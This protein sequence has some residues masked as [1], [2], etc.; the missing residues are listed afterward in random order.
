MKRS[1]L[2]Y[3]LLI[4]LTSGFGQNLYFPPVN[5][6]QWDT[7]GLTE[8]GWCADQLPP[9]YDFLESSNTKA[10][11]VLKDGK[12]AIEKY[13][14]SFTQDSLWYWASAGKT[15]TAFMVGKAQ[16]EGFLEISDTS[17]TYLGQGW[18]SLPSAQEEKI[19]VR[20]Q[21]T[22]TTG[23][24]DGVTDVNCTL[25]S[26]LQYLA[27][28]GTRWSYHNAPYTLL[29]DVVAAATNSNFNLYLNTKLKVPT[30]MDGLFVPVPPYQSVYFS[31]PRSMAR[32][33]LLML[34][35]GNWNGTQVMTDINYLNEMVTPSQTINNSYGYLWWLN[36]Q[37]S[38]MLPGI[39]IA[40]PGNLMP[41]APTDVYAAMGKNG[42]ILN[43]SPS[44]N[45][46]VVRMGDSPDNSFVP[47]L[48]N[49]TI[50]Q[51]LNPVMCGT[52]SEPSYENNDLNFYP[53]PTNGNLTINGIDKTGTLKLYSMDGRLMWKKFLSNDN[54][55]L[56]IPERIPRGIYIINISSEATSI[57]KKV[58]LK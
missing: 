50:W 1:I 35:N 37:S 49:D 38:F 25:S 36:G 13:F 21:L 33:G 40:F 20:H 5:S 4:S 39:Q 57:S 15:L 22:M 28:P 30:G 8:L 12:I 48:F 45:L 32:F 11:I 46:I 55:S 10:F 3:A 23:F 58:I 41:N 26:C 34:N 24:D 54:S 47:N 29:Q 14:G 17:S 56:Q 6:N 31:K 27:D 43:V 44:N 9:L 51:K 42:Q 16:E 18:T 2:L 7:V 19:T 53:N 52:A